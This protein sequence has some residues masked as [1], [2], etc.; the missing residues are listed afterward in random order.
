VDAEKWI[1]HESNDTMASYSYDLAKFIHGTL[2]SMEGQPDD[3][4][5]AVPDGHEDLG[6]ALQMSLDEGGKDR[7]C[8]ACHNFIFPLL[9]AANKGSKWE[10][11]LQSFLPILFLRSDGNFQSAR[12]I[13]PHLARWKYIC[14]CVVLF[15]A[16][17]QVANFAGDLT[18]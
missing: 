4:R 16:K 13:T 9:S 18:V 12:E 8:S 11:A 14:R 15:E 3:Y 5:I 2:L 1:P 10:D 7:I 6:R 17:A